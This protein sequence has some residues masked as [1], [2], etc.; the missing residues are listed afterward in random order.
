[1]RAA[2]SRQVLRGSLA[3]GAHGSAPES[4]GEMLMES[5]ATG[6]VFECRPRGSNATSATL[7]LPRYPRMHSAMIGRFRGF[8]RR[9][10]VRGGIGGHSRP[11]GDS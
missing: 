2:T 5:V 4:W 10:L 11:Q 6:V 1:M 9:F 7:P 3:A 8:S